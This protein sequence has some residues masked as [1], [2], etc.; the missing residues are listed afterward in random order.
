M[1][2][3][4]A[5]QNEPL[6]PVISIVIVSYNV[7]EFLGQS[8]N[9]IQNALVEIP[10]EIFVVDNASSDNSSGFIKTQFPQIKL[11]ENKTNLGFGKA[12]N[13]ALKLCKGQYVCV[14]NPDTI[15]Q[16]NTFIK[17][18]DFLKNQNDA[19]AAGC[20]ILNPDGT[21]QL[22]CRRSYP[23]PWVSFTKMIGLARLFPQSK[24]FGRYNLTFLDPE[25]T[26]A[27]E[28]ISGSF[29]ILKRKVIDQVGFFDESFFM[30]GEDLD[31]CYRINQAGYK[32]YYVP[33]TQIIHFKGESS[34]K[35]PFEQRRLFYEAMHL[36]V[37]KHFS[38]SKA[39]LPSW[40]LIAAIWVR[41]A[42]SIASAAFS[43]IAM[44]FVDLSIM[45]LSLVFAI[46]YRFNPEFPWQPF[47]FV[48]LVYSVVW[49]LSLSFYGAYGRRKYSGLKTFLG[50]FVGL[51]INSALTYF[52]K[53]YGFSRMVILIAGILNLVFVPGW[54]TGLKILARSGPA[55]IS[56]KFSHILL[57]RRTILVGD[58]SSCEKLY[59]NILSQVDNTYDVKGI[60]VYREGE[61]QDNTQIP[62]LGQ[63]EFLEEIIEREKIQEVIFS[64]DK[65][66]YNRL[67]KAIINTKSANVV[68]KMVPTN[69]DVI[70]GKA[71]IEYLDDIPLL[72]LEY[73]LHNTFYQ[74]LKRWFDIVLSLI[75]IILLSPLFLWFLLI[76]REKE[77]ILFDTNSR[78]ALTFTQY[79]TSKSGSRLINKIPFLVNILKGE[80]SFVGKDLNLFHAN[81]KSTGN[82]LKYGLTGLEQ[83][84]PL[85]KLEKSDRERLQLFYLKNYSPLFDVEILIK[86]FFHK[87][88]NI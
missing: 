79:K 57:N 51:I 60:V 70:I 54:R 82:K 29:M 35:S 78:K 19:G 23:T 2:E 33:T 67:L 7:R 17:L 75:G 6:N 25:Q 5:K 72:D 85:K 52:F 1:G 36:F 20:K 32:I 45:T 31:W 88:H 27:V 24:L 74:N 37:Q 63:I 22:A 38:G 9:S 12:N 56:N 66:P 41:A 69:L 61:R 64:T 87:K 11:I 42:F 39:V 50:I 58:I 84:S 4:S 73:K 18:I 10:H 15:V 86:A 48:H 71:T 55:F 59:S 47:I 43:K 21:L 77:D 16:E 49:L 28:A 40:F 65:I 34:K 76:R 44:P 3:Q 46:F 68:F 26:A 80:I 14:I 13:Q 53:Q 81:S 83:L 62:I 8:I 30:Y